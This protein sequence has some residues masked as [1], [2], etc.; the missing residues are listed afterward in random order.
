MAFT[1]GS[2]MHDKTF[3]LDRAIARSLDWAGQY[4]ALTYAAHDSQSLSNGRQVVAA[5]I[6]ST[7][8]RASSSALSGLCLTSPLRGMSSDVPRRGG[9]SYSAGISGLFPI[10]RR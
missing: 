10:A 9:I 2:I 3:F 6:S 7:G 1:R 4:P 5:A 8:V